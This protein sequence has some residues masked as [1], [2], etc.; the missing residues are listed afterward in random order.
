MDN[1]KIINYIKLREQWRD[2]QSEKARAKGEIKSGAWSLGLFLT[3]WAIE[4]FLLDYDK[5]YE[6]MPNFKYVFYV[7]LAIGL[8]GFATFLWGIFQFFQA[9][10]QA[11]Q[12]RKQVEQLE[13]E[14]ES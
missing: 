9:S 1:L 8:M 10:Q 6:Q 2:W 5:I 3:Y 7:S 4:K 12:L 11:E 14:L 13:R